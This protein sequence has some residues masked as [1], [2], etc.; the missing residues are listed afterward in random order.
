VTSPPSAHTALTTACAQAG[1]SADRACILY[2][3]A[4]TV[5]RLPATPYVARV[6]PG[7]SA[8]LQ[9]R[10]SASVQVT[11]WLHTMGFPA[12]RPADVDQPVITSGHI[13]TFWHYLPAVESPG[14]DVASLARLLRQLHQLP[15]PPVRLPQTSPFGSLAHDARRCAWLTSQQRSWLLARCAD[16]EHQYT[17]TTWTQGSGLIHGDAYTEN[18][19]HT[20]DNVVLSDW[21]SAGHAPREQDLVPTSIRRRFGLPQTAWEEFC[22]LYGVD[23]ACLPGFPLLERIRELRT[24]TAYLRSNH[25]QARAE[26]SHRLTDLMTGTQHHPWQG[27]NLAP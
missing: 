24:L 11:R 6:R 8:A 18:L 23:P 10:M 20:R 7:G 16:L 4:N 25:P 3:R 14:Y 9:Q 21:D 15:P 5:Y 22:R 13:V 1:L 19:I 17:A 27:L 2:Q 26:I 12:V